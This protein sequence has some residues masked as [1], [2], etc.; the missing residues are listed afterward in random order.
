MKKDHYQVKYVVNGVTHFGIV[1]SFSD[2]AIKYAKEGK[3]IVED[4]VLPTRNIV[5]ES[6][7]IDLPMDWRD[8]EFN[9]E[10]NR[11]S[12]AAHELSESLPDG[13]VV[14]KLFSVGV[15]DGSASY[16]VTRITK[17]K[18]DVEWRG[19]CPDRW[20]DHYWGYGRKN[21]PISDVRR[22]VTRTEGLSKIFGKKSR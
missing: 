7:V 11:L 5:N 21:V 16:V 12:D 22:Y 14:G 2:E 6:E 8:G 10:L 17:T 20:T 19:F 15:A 3:L 18:C 9:K 13:V 4:I 1:D